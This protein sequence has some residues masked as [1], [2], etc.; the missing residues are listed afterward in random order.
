MRRRLLI[1][2]AMVATT[3]ALVAPLQAMASEVQAR[4]PIVF[5]HGW[6]GGAWR[7]DL[8]IG[9]LRADG[10]SSGELFAWSYNT[11]Q[12]NAVTAQQLGQFVNAVLAATAFD[13]LVL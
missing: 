4:N 3:F 1:L 6:N 2:L 10:Y 11:S 5:V 7:W 13:W 8:M 12:S 9:R